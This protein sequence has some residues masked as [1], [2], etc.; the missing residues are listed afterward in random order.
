MGKSEFYNG[1]RLLTM[2]DID[3]ETP[4][5]FIVDGNRSAGKSFFFKELLV[6]H[7]LKRGEKFI[8]LARQGNEINGTIEAF[9]KDIVEVKFPDITYSGEWVCDQL[10]QKIYI[11]DKHAGYCIALNQADKIKKK[12]TMFVDAAAIFFDEFQTDRYCTDEVNKFISIHISIARG[13]GKHTRYVPVY[14]CSNHVSILNP[15]YIVFGIYK[16]W[17]PQQYFFMRGPGWVFEF[18]FNEEA[19]T[20]IIQTGFGKAVASS[21]YMQHATQNSSLLDNCNFVC[22]VKGDKRIFTVLI[23]DGKEFG[24]WN[25]NDDV[26]YVSSKTEPNWPFKLTFKTSDHNVSRILQKKGDYYAK[27]MRDM[28]NQGRMRFESLEA[29]DAFLDF[30]GYTLI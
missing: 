16:R 8:I 12:S 10:F 14:M 30:I 23:R 7:F 29:K 15:Y 3:G 28:F 9:F 24:V 6:K 4:E 13:G 11:N 20:K 25:V 1:N 17:I 5:I 27:A 2:K 18:T 19:A 21:T 26:L 22:K